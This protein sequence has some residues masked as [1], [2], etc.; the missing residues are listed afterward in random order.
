[1]S[2]ATVDAVLRSAR[3][4]LSAARIAGGNLDARVLVAAATG[5]DSAGLIARGDSPVPPDVAARIDAWIDQRIAGMPVGRIL[6]HREFHGLD[7]ALGPD[8]LEPRPD[9]ETLVDRAVDIVRSWQVPGAG[10][11]GRGL[12]FADIGTGTGAIAVAVAVALPAARGIATDLSPGA[13]TVARANAERH[14]VLDRLDFRLG[15]M[16]APIVEPVGLILSNPPYIETAAL[17]GL[18]REV[19]DHDPRLALDGGPDGLDAYRSLAQ[20]AGDALV[21]GGTIAVEIG[22]RQGPV[23]SA[24][25]AAVGL[26][27]VAVH[28]DLAGRDRVVVARRS[29]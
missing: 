28:P 17:D 16:L 26:D 25:F 7:F 1:M 15:D 24:L 18:D 10:R 4:R 8:T 21:P 29:V 3:R 2:D 5:L 14:K 6:G 27:G 13:L 20:G 23:V 12:L 19:R 9:T 11:D 22:Y